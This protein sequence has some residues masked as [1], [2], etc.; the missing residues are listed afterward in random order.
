[1]SLI[2]RKIKRHKEYSG[3]VYGD[4]RDQNWDHT[5]QKWG[6]GRLENN[7]CWKRLMFCPHFKFEFLTNTKIS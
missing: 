2:A 1:M 5:K 3:N 4:H 6:C 7:W